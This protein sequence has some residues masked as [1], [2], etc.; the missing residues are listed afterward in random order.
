[1]RGTVCKHIHLV[2][3]LLSDSTKAQS[4]PSLQTKCETA[5]NHT[6]ELGMLVDTLKQNTK[7]KSN[8]DE[9]KGKKKQAYYNY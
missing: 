6:D 2:S 8:L 4:Q 7:M 3:L 9:L 5:T 1:M